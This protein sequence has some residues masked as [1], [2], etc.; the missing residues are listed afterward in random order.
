MGACDTDKKTLAGN[1]NSPAR[2]SNEL[3]FRV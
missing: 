3:V 1:T 2:E